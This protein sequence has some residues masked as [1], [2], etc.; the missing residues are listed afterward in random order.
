MA[1]YHS[2]TEIRM[3]TGPDGYKGLG[4]SKQVDMPDNATDQIIA[5]IQEFKDKME[6]HL[7]EFE[8][9]ADDQDTQ[10]SEQISHG[11]FFLKEFRHHQ[12][13]ANVSFDRLRL[14]YISQVDNLKKERR[15][16]KKDVI[17]KKISLEEKLADL[18]KELSPF[19]LF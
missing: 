13:D 5:P 18:K 15:Q 10:I 8:H 9:E 16:L 1:E 11:E 6:E 3:L 19:K 7:T 2:K 4:L 17:L 12:W 14:Q